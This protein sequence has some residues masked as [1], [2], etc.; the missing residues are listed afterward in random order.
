MTAT[1]PVPGL[2][3]NNSK[4]KSKENRLAVIPA[5]TRIPR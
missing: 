5:I 1:I 3:D 4:L 2:G